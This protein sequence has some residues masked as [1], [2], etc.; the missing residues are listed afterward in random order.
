VVFTH[1]KGIP[2]VKSKPGKRTKPPTPKQLFQRA[3][4]HTVMEFLRP[5]R[6]VVNRYFEAETQGRTLHN[7][8][9]SYYLNHVL[10]VDG[11]QLSI[12]VDKII[13]TKGGLRGL[14]EVTCNLTPEGNL[15]IAWKYTPNEAG[16]NPNDSLYIALY[17]PDLPSGLLLLDTAHREDSQMQISLPQPYRST[18]IH[19]W[20]GFIAHDQ[21]Q[22]SW[23]SYL[24]L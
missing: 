4:L 23:S 13:L 20:T 19:F 18:V 1:W 14:E 16:S 15:Y 17:A 10:R 22:A 21:S 3:K 5:Y 9:N 2:I 8:S 6:W 7:I 11:E 12:D 24:Q